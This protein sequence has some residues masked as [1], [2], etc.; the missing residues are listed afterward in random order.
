LSDCRWRLGSKV[1]CLRLFGPWILARRLRSCRTRRSCTRSRGFEYGRSVC[2]YQGEGP[3]T[4][5]RSLSWSRR[6]CFEW[7]SSGLRP[8]GAAVVSLVLECAPGFSSRGMTTSKFL[9]T[10]YS[11]LAVVVVFVLGAL[12]RSSSIRSWPPGCLQGECWCRSKIIA[13][14]ATTFSAPGGDRTYSGRGRYCYL[15]DGGG[16]VVVRGSWWAGVTQHQPAMSLSHGTKHMLR[17]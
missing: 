6:P 7:R 13:C 3:A 1:V 10:V 16:G 8:G 12:R 5:A 4:S 11:V 2:E 14:A 15:G 9:M 17:Y